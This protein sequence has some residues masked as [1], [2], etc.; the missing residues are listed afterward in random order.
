[1]NFFQ[2]LKHPKFEN[3]EPIVNNISD[4]I[5]KAILKYRKHPGVIAIRDKFKIKETFSFVEVD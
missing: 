3:N 4:P 2:T 5:L 1:M